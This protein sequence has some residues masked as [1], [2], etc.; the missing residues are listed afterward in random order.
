ML[1][2]VCYAGVAEFAHSKLPDFGIEV[3][4]IDFSDLDTLATAIRPNTKLLWAESPCN[5]ILRLTDLAAVSAM[6]HQSGAQLAVDSTLATPVATRPLSMGA[7]FVVHSL[8]KY[9]NGHGDSMGGRDWETR[10]SRRASS[11]FADPHGWSP[12]HSMPGSCGGECT[13][14]TFECGRTPKVHSK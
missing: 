8:T 10:S 12:E 7:D 13:R 14:L 2:D 1:S 5:P 9:L 3:T 11:V 6:A 4:S